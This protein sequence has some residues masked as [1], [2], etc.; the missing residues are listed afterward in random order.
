MC[1][2]N[3]RKV[4]PTPLFLFI[5]ILIK[6][7]EGVSGLKANTAQNCYQINPFFHFIIIFLLISSSFI[8]LSPRSFLVANL[9][10]RSKCPSVSRLGGNVIFLAPNWDF[11]PIFLCV[12][13]PL[14]NE[15]LFCKY[16]VR[17]SVGNAT[18]GFATYGCFHPCIYRNLIYF[19]YFPWTKK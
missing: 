17:L 9:L 3:N 6:N 13:I 11:A 18:K 12:Q 10:Y 14:I 5:F 2:K 7:E 15:H 19:L 8:T 4:T 1:I 16:F